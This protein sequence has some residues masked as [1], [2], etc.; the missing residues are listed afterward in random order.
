MTIFIISHQDI[1]EC[2]TG[3]HSCDKNAF[4]FDSVGGYT[5]VCKEG[6]KEYNSGRVCLKG[7]IMLS[8]WEWAQSAIR[9][10]SFFM[11]F[12]LLTNFVTENIKTNRIEPLIILSFPFCSEKGSG[13][14][15]LLLSILTAFPICLLVIVLVGFGFYFQR[16][17]CI[18]R[19]SAGH[20]VFCCS[21][22]LNQ[23][24]IVFLFYV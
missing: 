1:D 10:T 12:L 9:H 3:T 22:F 17:T 11:Q 16:Y 5:C 24:Y 20:T 19:S 21:D 4:C 23:S 18:F 2:K 6:Y 7:L 14:N 8:A 13:K 15:N